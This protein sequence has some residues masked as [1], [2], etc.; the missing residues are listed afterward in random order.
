MA[1]INMTA[2]WVAIGILLLGLALAYAIKRLDLGDSVTLIAL[3]L[4]P[5]IAYGIFSTSQSI[6]LLSL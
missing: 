6:P 2:I 4:I 3:L 5:L 1:R